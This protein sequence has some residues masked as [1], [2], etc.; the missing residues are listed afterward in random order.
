VE[1]VVVVIDL[2]VVDRRLLIVVP[3]ANSVALVLLVASFVDSVV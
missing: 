1:L 3:V 2:G